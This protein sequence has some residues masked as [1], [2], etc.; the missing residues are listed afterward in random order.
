MGNLLI[1]LGVLFVA[2]IVVVK[3]TERYAKPM[4]AEQQSKL[5]RI[6]M[7]LMALLLLAG[8]MRQCTGG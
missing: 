3:V 8:L 2:L 5:S 4:E 6:A 1:I 7:I